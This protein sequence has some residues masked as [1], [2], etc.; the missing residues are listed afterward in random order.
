MGG[1]QPTDPKGG[2]QGRVW[3]P[4]IF[5]LSFQARWR[6]RLP[7]AKGTGQVACQSSQRHSH[8]PSPSLGPWK[9]RAGG[10]GGPFSLEYPYPHRLCRDYFCKQPKAATVQCPIPWTKT[11][12]QSL[13]CFRHPATSPLI[14]QPSAEATSPGRRCAEPQ[15]GPRSLVLKT[16]AVCPQHSPSTKRQET[17]PEPFKTIT[18]QLS[19]HARGTEEERLADYEVSKLLQDPSPGV[20]TP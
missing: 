18:S 9:I 20:P 7:M 4:D 16:L 2:E 14:S 10:K 5:S 6:G 1:N 15:K 8:V 13:V 19:S 17:R 3:S 11:G 12:P